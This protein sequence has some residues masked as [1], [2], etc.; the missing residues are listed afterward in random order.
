MMQQI[1]E[2]SVLAAL[3]L[4]WLVQQ[5]RAYKGVNNWLIWAGIGVVSLLGWFW[6]TPL[7]VHAFEDNW[8]LALVNIITF[9]TSAAGFGTM[10]KDAHVAPAGNTK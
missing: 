5:A 8:R 3:G 10:T 1:P 9:A 4:G 2:V 7:A 6:A